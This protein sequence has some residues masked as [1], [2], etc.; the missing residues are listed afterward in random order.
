MQ[1]HW[2]N[3]GTADLPDI[4]TIAATVH[5]D[6][7]ERAEVIAEK[8]RLCPD[9]C[10]V[11]VGD[12][13]IAGYGLAHFWTL[14]TI[15]PLDEFLSSLPPSPDCLYIHDIAVRPAS[16]GGR[17]A[18]AYVDGITELARS[19][20]ITHLA[21]VSVYDTALFWARLGFRIVAP[22]AALRTKL[23]S[24]GQGAAYMIADLDRRRY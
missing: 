11:L 13:K 19:A 15:P 12:G 1:S 14:H 24:Y 6:L 7:P 23:T 8:I 17:V 18:D 2:R 10:R 20:Q 16:R 5:P 4:M 9:G 3:A 22:D 21:L